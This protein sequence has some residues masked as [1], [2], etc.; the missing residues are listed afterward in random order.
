M[1]GAPL[2]PHVLHVLVGILLAVCRSEGGP[3]GTFKP[4]AGG[5]IPTALLPNDWAVS[6]TFKSANEFKGCSTRSSHA[7]SLPLP[8]VETES[9]KHSE[10]TFSGLKLQTGR[11]RMSSNH[12]NCGQCRTKRHPACR[13]M[14]ALSV[15]SVCRLWRKW[16]R[17]APTGAGSRLLELLATAPDSGRGVGS[18]VVLCAG[19]RR[20]G[21]LEALSIHPPSIHLSI[22]LSIYLYIHLYI[23]LSNYV[24]IYLSIYLSTYLFCWL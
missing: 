16:L 6:V 14:P 9:S 8:H 2:M 3:A 20:L 22:Y 12:L 23:Y 17:L 15:L 1:K 18:R 13:R 11:Q 5:R 10:L 24:S 21:H 19:L 7:A 4:L